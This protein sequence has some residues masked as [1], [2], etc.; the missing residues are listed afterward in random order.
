MLS[1]RSSPLQ[2]QRMRLIMAPIDL[3]ATHQLVRINVP[4]LGRRVL[5]LDCV[6][7]E[8]SP[9]YFQV[10][11]LPGQLPC[12][13]IDTGKQCT[14]SFDVGGLVYVVRANIAEIIPPRRLRL[15]NVRS[16]SNIQKREYFRVNT[17][18]SL[19]YQLAAGTEPHEISDTSV[20][21]SGGGIRFP[22]E[23]RVRLRDRVAVR[24][25]LNGLP[26]VDA[27]C[28]GRVVRIDENPDGKMEIA[29]TFIEIS[30]RD[31]DRII[32]HCFAQQRE[33]LRKRVKVK[34]EPV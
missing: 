6:P 5:E 13:E 14:L 4:L 28:T 24:L 25:C 27:E 20:N 10:E 15:A 32:S 17:E 33:Q 18:V 2:R 7:V 16:Y 1:G 22:I 23:G 12:D 19:Q 30:P 3:L 9:P 34:P 21:L 11:F 26:E 31:R 8:N 29:L